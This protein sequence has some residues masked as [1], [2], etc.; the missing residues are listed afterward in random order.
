MKAFSTSLGTAYGAVTLGLLLAILILSQQ[1]ALAVVWDRNRAALETFAACRDGTSVASSRLEP[2]PWLMASL[3]HCQGDDHQEQIAW[4]A[5]LIGSDQR[6]SVGQAARPDDALLARM[7]A[8]RYPQNA[9]AQFWLAENLNSAGDV[10]GAIQAYELGLQI[11]PT[12]GLNWR[13]LGDLYRQQGDWQKA[14][15]AYDQ[16][17]FWVDSGHNGCYRAGML[18]HE[19]GFYDKAIQRFESTIFQEQNWIPGY[20]ALVKV[21]FEAGRNQDARPYLEYLASQGDLEA[22]QTLQELFPSQP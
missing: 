8:E 14:V 5:S 19:H 17:C 22:T 3:A 4:L 9:S 6:L 21:L 1:P 16:A 13:K 2:Y 18:Y 11:R 7:A 12:N 10:N 15:K 20:R